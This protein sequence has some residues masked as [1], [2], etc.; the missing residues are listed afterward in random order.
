[1]SRP[2]PAELESILM[3]CLKK[4]PEQRPESAAE[5]R[6]MLRACTNLG[7]WDLA[8]ARAWWERHGQAVRALHVHSEEIAV[9]KTVDINMHV[10]RGS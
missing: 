7:T 1:M 10:L 4:D 8:E 2:V 5:L 9:A 6:R 3:A